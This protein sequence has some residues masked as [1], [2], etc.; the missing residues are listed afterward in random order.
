[1]PRRHVH[2]AHKIPAAAAVR[3]PKVLLVTDSELQSGMSSL[4]LPAFLG[5]PN[6]LVLLT[7]SAREGSAAAAL[8]AQPTPVQ[9]EPTTLS[10]ITTVTTS[11]TSPPRHLT[12]SHHPTAS[13]PH[14]LTT[15]P[16]HHL[17]TLTTSPPYYLTHVWTAQY[18]W[19]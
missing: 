1:M 18:S 5:Q 8:A 3:G 11:T 13:P 17:T 4:M 6:S 14:R 7:Q 10:T 19:S 15:S 2:T 16:P 9:V 12:T